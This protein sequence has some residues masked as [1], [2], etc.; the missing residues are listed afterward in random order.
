MLTTDDQTLKFTVNGKDVEEHVATEEKLL[1]VLRENLDLTGAKKA[2]DNGECGSCIVLMNG[3]P[4]KSC[5][6]PASRAAGK[7]VV[8]IEGLSGPSLEGI[9]DRILHPLQQAFLELGA[10]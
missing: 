8:T 5:L 6:L 1:E 7:E 4:T 3:K 2:C 9:E 10:T